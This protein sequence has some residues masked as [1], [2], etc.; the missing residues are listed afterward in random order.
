MIY[1]SEYDS[2]IFRVTEPAYEIQGDA[3]PGAA[4]NRQGVQE[5][6]RPGYW[7]RRDRW[8]R[9]PP[10][11]S[12]LGRQN[13]CLMMNCGSKKPALLCFYKKLII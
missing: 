10:L 6:G 1:Y 11:L 12:I 8:P 5:T 7:H 2:V 3:S 9:I 13:R 4:R